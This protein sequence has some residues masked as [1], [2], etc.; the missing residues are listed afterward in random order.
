MNKALT[1]KDCPFCGKPGVVKI[2]PTPYRHGWVGCPECH[3]YINWVYNLTPAVDS[4][5]KRAGGVA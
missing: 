4:W 3:C 2:L 1:I 5:N